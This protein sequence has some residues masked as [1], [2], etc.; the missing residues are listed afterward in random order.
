MKKL[1]VTAD[2][3]GFSLAVNK[4]VED[5]HQKG[6]LTSTSLMIGGDAAQDAIERARRLPSLRVGLHV[7]LSGSRPFLPPE[8]V[9][10]LLNG[11]GEFL[12]NLTK[13]GFRYFFNPRAKVQLE[14][15]IR[16]QFQAF[17]DSGLL[18]DHVN[19]H[20]HMHFHPTIIKLILKVGA[21]FGLKAIRFPN[22]PFLFSRI[23]SMKKNFRMLGKRLFLLPWIGILRFH[24]RKANIKHNDF[25]FGMDDSGNMNA[26]RFTEI[27]ENLPHGVSE[28][29]FHPVVEH[30]SELERPATHNENNVDYLTLTGQN[31]RDV[32]KRLDIQRTTFTDLQ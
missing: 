27:L 16:A 10:A 2:D 3:F 19:A 18:L 26:E 4:A 29:Y 1:I 24:M 25:M 23:S 8:H 17:K 20:H 11:N 12:H 9:P 7:V 6:I 31:A 22:G 30:F 15:E 32:L 5:S 28:V 21:E 13:A 14:A